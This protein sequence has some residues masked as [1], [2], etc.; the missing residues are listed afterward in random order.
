MKRSRDDG[1][2][3]K[4]RRKLESELVETGSDERKASTS[5]ATIENNS[6]IPVP[7]DED[8]SHVNGESSTHQKR[9][10]LLKVLDRSSSLQTSEFDLKLLV[11]DVRPRSRSWT[12]G[13]AASK[14]AISVT[15]E[16]TDTR[17]WHNV[18]FPFPT[19]FASSSIPKDSAEDN[20]RV[21]KRVKEWSEINFSTSDTE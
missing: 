16:E 9:K 13:E 7:A 2:P 19:S 10:P 6:S 20:V 11:G 14:G 18:T 8:V 15:R 3:E 5:K 12:A 21:L 1:S 17:A 4:K